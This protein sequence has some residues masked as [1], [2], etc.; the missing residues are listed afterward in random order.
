MKDSLIIFAC[1]IG[2]G[3]VGYFMGDPIYPQ[4]HRAGGCGHWCRSRVVLS[5]EYH[6]WIL[7][8][9]L[10]CDCRLDLKHHTRG[11]CPPDGPTHR[12]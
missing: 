1:L 7:W 4:Y 5:L 9:G 2:G 6:H 10:A 3:L 8:S 11:D 12:E